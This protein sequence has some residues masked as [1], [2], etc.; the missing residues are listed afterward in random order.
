MYIESSQ[1]DDQPLV[2][3]CIVT[4][5]HKRYIHDCIMSVIAQSSDVTLEILVGD[6]QSDDGTSG[7][8]E[9]LTKEYPHFI[10]NFRHLKRI[11]YGS[12]NYLYLL[13][14]T[15]G[16]YIAHLDGDDYWL[17][18]KLKAQVAFLEQNPTCSAVYTNALVIQENNEPAGIFNNPQPT[19]FD[20]NRLLGQ[21]NFLNNS[22][23]L[24]RASFKQSILDFQAPFID[25]Q[26]NLSHALSGSLG[27]LNQALT[28]YRLNSSSSVL[29]QANERIRKLYWDALLNLP[30]A[31]V[32]TDALA[33]GMSEF[34][35]SVFFRSLRIKKISLFKKWLPIVLNSSPVGKAKTIFFVLSAI[36]RV[37]AQEGLASLSAKLGGNQMKIL[38]R[39]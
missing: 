17:P 26:I 30:R 22:S 4:Y 19:K 5:N 2:S 1:D 24:Y 23:M 6:D 12:K 3:V 31:S 18:G 29:V 7:I 33:R 20:I 16:T 13:Q 38:Y 32:N 36:F 9:V 37:A 27:Y 14:K 15:R 10:R 8:I 25:Y 28:V 34:G 21:G 11:G 39:R 35:R